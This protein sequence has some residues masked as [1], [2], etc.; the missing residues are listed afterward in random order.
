MRFASALTTKTDWAEAVEDL[1][2]QVAA[3]LGTVETQLAVLFAHPGTFRTLKQI[4]GATRKAVKAQHLLGCTG[5]GIIGTDREVEEKPALSLLVGELPGVTIYP[6]ELAEK[7]L[8]ES[9]G[10]AF[11]HYQLELEP[12]VNPSSCCSLT[13]L[14]RGRCSLSTRW[15]KRI[16]RRP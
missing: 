10:A 13:P 12:S 3:Q 5:A 16:R 2:R 9:T 7:E 1:G 15:P 11:W 6:F 8:E 4:I 14:R